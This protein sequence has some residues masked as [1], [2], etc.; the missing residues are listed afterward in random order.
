[1][2]R[3]SVFNP[4]SNPMHCCRLA[5]PCFAVLWWQARL[6]EA[7]RSIRPGQLSAE[8]QARNTLGDIQVRTGAQQR[9]RPHAGGD[10][11][12]PALHQRPRRG[13]S[14]PTT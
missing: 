13:Y 3:S 9:K 4:P 7:A 10:V 6:L 12:A 14:T 8:E 1:M 5:A 11:A 2:L